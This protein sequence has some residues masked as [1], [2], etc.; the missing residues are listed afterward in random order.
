MRYLDPREAVRKMVL[1]FGAEQ[2]AGLIGRTAK[3]VYNKVNPSQVRH[4]LMFDEV[5]AWAGI[6]GSTVVVE[7]W[8]RQCGGVFVPMPSREEVTDEA[9]FET[10][11][12]LIAQLGEFSREFNEDIRRGRITGRE[13]ARLEKDM[14]DFQADGEELLMRLRKK[15]KL[16]KDS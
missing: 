3:W 16:D 2:L 10:Y 11:T 9:L 14:R 5:L 13:L 12:H 7:A 6:T 15:S 4:P 8:A 1:D